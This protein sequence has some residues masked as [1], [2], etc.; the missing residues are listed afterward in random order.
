VIVGSIVGV[1]TAAVLLVVGLI[2]LDDTLFLSSIVAS[3][4]A[5]LALVVGVRQFP[6]GRLPEV[7][8]DVR[9]GG[10][11]LSR[12]P[13]KPIGRAGV[14]RQSRISIGGAIDGA[15]AH[16]SEL[17]V[18]RLAQADETIPSDEPTE[19]LVTGEAAARVAKLRA[20]V[21]VVDD[22]PRYHVSEC[23]HLL[24]RQGQRLSAREATQLGFTPCSLCEPVTALLASG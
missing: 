11:G 21:V 14:P 15:H 2:R 16:L 17:D 18:A 3:A 9:P 20:E 24:G 12:R 19:Q 13:G 22:R 4:V 23:L 6:A 8:F 1:L 10:P 7:D 5:A